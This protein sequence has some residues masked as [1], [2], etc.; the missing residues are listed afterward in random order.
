MGSFQVRIQFKP[1]RTNIFQSQEN[2]NG[3]QP[4]ELVIKLQPTEAIYLKANIKEP[5][6]KVGIQQHMR[7]A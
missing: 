2:G 4:N 1:T 3:E 7:G 6:L 5:G